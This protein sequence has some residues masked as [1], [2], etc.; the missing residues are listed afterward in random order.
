VLA[1]AA[2]AAVVNVRL[3]VGAGRR[4]RGGGAPHP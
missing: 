3:L 1:I 4:V 2:T